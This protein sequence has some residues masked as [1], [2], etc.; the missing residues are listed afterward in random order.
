[1]QAISAFSGGVLAQEIVKCSGKFTPIPGFLHFCAREALP[2]EDGNALD[3]N[4]RGS[5]LDE[6]AAMYGWDMVEKL[7]KLKY[8][9]VGCGA[10]GCEFMKNFALNGICCGE[11]GKLYVTDADRIE[12][13]NLSRQF[14]FRE[15]NVGQPKSRAAAAMAKVMNAN[16][17][18]EALEIFVGTKTENVFNDEFW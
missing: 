18:V 1:M 11:G 15:H 3:L 14:L 8:F 17:T 10:L 5:R 6:L 4:P 7:G 2:S 16:F 9:M 12:L 13:S